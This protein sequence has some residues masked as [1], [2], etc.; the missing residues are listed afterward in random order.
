MQ[1]TIESRGGPIIAAMDGSEAS[2]DAFNYA[3]HLAA[4]LG[5]TVEVITVLGGRSVGYFYAFVDEQLLVEQASNIEVVFEKARDLGRQRGVKVRTVMREA[6]KHRSH[7]A[8]LEYLKGKEEVAMLV[9]GSY[10]RGYHDRHIL[11]STTEKLIRNISRDGLPIPVVVVPPS[12]CSW[13]QACSL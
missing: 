2:W 9:V 10:G 3:V 1:P 11:G 6:G 8:I 4:H 12:F 13:P 7:Q 5:L